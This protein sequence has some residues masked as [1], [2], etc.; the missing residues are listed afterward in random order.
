MSPPRAPFLRHDRR[1]SMRLAVPEGMLYAG[2][3][4]CA[5]HWFVVDAI[6]LGATPFEQGLVVGLPLF[7]GALGPLLAVRLLGSIRSRRG[8]VAGFVF[9]QAFA[10]LLIAL[11]DALALQTPALLIAGASL[12]QV[13][14]QGASPGWTSWYGDLVPERLR[15]SYFAHRTRAVQ[16]TICGAMVVAGFALQALEPTLCFGVP[17]NAWWPE[18]A[19]PGRG[20]TLVF[21]AAALCR[22]ASAVLLLLAPEPK[23]TGL[24]SRGKVA[25]FLRTERGGNA[26]RLVVGNAAY[27]AAVYLASP[28]FLPFMAQELHFSYVL[29]MAALASQVGLKAVLQRKYGEW[30]DRHGA[31]PV[32]LIGVLGV[33]LAPL[34]FLWAERWPS[35]FAS[36]LAS[37]VAWGCLEIGLFVLLLQATFRNTRVHAIA[38]HTG[39][40]GLGQLTGSL[41]G[42]ALLAASGRNYHLVIAV[43]IGARLLLALLAAKLVRPRADGSDTGVK[44]LLLKGLR[45]RNGGQAAVAGTSPMEST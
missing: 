4:G 39:M 45:R 33:A 27:Y 31:R 15:G 17:T 43:S 30:I 20:F 25:Q 6:R 3:V 40:N 28:F 24:A 7:I 44:E 18:L 19:A 12:Y 10:L 34:P 2:M 23:F 36:Q 42:G 38:A 9:A 22:L 14:G 26:W 35:V 16:Y 41:A 1:R 11:L 8:L 5:E 13:A 32:F 21:A 37:G 29:L